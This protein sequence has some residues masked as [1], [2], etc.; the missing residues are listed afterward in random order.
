MGNSREGAS[1]EGDET[2]LESDSGDGCPT[3]SIYKPIK[4]YAVKGKLYGT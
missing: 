4:L 2:V 3:L 1:W